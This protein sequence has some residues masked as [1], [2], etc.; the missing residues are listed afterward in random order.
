MSELALFSRSS[1]D[2]IG[3]HPMHTEVFTVDRSLVEALVDALRG[4]SPVTAVGTTSVRTLESLP[5]L[6]MAVAD[7][8]CSLGRTVDGLHGRFP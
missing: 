8:D 6:G 2:L 7:G 3:D 4:G 5:Y 1:P